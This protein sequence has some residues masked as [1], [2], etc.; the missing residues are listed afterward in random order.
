MELHI[1]R[2]YFDAI[3]SGKKTYEWRLAKD[4]YRLLKT[5]DLIIFK[6]DWNEEVTRHISSIHIYDSF[7]SAWKNLWIEKIIPWTQNIDEMINIYRQFYT[8]QDE[9]AFN[10]IMLWIN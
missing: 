3:L 8:E 5:W 10:V 9:M 4:K 6:T 2:K 1:Q 7:K